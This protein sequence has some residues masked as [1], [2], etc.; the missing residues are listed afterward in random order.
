MGA[1]S[2]LLYNMSKPPINIDYIN[3]FMKMKRRG[4]DDTQLLVENTPII[5]TINTQ[6]ISSIL[7]K[8]EIKEYKQITYN[9][10]YHR[11]SINDISEDGSQPFEDP[12]LHKIS[13]YPELRIR[14]KRKLL[15]NGE[16][17]NYNDLVQSE[18]F[19]DKDLQS[20]SDCE[21][22][23]PLY[24]KCAEKEQNSEKGLVECLKK[25]NGEY[26]FVLTENTTT[27]NLKNIN[28]F[29]ARD[30]FGTRPL[31]MVKYSPTNLNNLNNI[32]NLNN[33]N[34]TSEMFYLFT[35][36]LKGIPKELFNN[37]DYIITEIPPGCYWSFNNI[38][39]NT[40]TD[41][42]IPYY[43]LSFYSKLSN[44]I[45]N[46]PNPDTLSNIYLNI[47]QIATKS[48]IERYNMSDRKV[49]VLLS[50]G[51]DSCIIVTILI[52]YLVENGF[53]DVLSVFTIG[54]L[55]NDDVINAKNHV[56]YLEKTFNLTIRHHIVTI[57]DYKLILP[58]IH[59]IIEAL[60]TYDSITIRKS[61][62][63]YYLLKY[64]KEK[65]DI[66]ILLSGEG[67]DE[68]C[69]Y[70]ELFKLND[71]EFREK[72][73]N[74]LFNLHKYDLL[75]SDKLSG[76]FGLEMRYPFLSKDFIEF[77]LS[78]HPSLQR[79]QM[80]GYSKVPIEKYIIRKSFENE[81]I[82]KDILW[83]SRK[84]ISNSFNTLSYFLKSYFSQIITDI[85]FTNYIESD[86]GVIPNSKEEMYYKKTFNMLFPNMENIINGYWNSLF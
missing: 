76:Y 50:G 2:F 78:I 40:F 25:I 65:C 44:C 47:N 9:Y 45:Y 75:R 27:F 36:E 59:N 74:L 29:V 13:S 4:E 84:D 73:I 79:P 70:D 60:E 5:N 19:T 38:I 64:I 43:D 6:Q 18:N 16:I 71:Q 37:P 83:N 68:C 7:S 12:I 21:V 53:N 26:S 17:Y 61:I 66:K 80:S 32:N 82:E 28:V 72:S 63:L 56:L 10:G 62:P 3:S 1:I 23:L 24:I 30:L 8:R 85:E 33:L 39:S 35:T 51:F 52:K 34:N 81:K 22:I 67:L 46:K 69:G 86:K 58:E 11:M 55:D 42:F 14:P 57:A 49:G 48:V 15:C 20:E 41:E 77:I 31:Y 54:D